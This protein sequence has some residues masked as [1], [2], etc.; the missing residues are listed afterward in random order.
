MG[1]MCAKKFL[2]GFLTFLVCF[3]SNKSIFTPHYVRCE[4]NKDNNFI[5][6]LQSVN[7]Q[8]LANREDGT[9]YFFLLSA[10]ILTLHQHPLSVLSE[11]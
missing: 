1:I 10:I 2:L 4:K 5:Y 9:D 7:F 8:E 11:Y 6:L 3:R